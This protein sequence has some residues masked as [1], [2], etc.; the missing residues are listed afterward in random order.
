ME[1]VEIRLAETA[2]LDFEDARSLKLLQ[3][4]SDAALPCAHILGELQLPRKAG[5][6]APC[7]FQQ[8][9]IGELG[10]DRNVFLYEDEIRHLREAMKGDGIGSDD[11]DVAGDV[12]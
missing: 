12:C 7:V 1:P 2:L 4:G 5:I 8:H 6:V 3:I 11:L 9:G 10:S